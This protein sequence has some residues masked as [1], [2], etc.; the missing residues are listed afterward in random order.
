MLTYLNVELLI[1]TFGSIT[2]PNSSMAL[3]MSRVAI[4]DTM[5]SQ[6]DELTRC[7]PGHILQRKYMQCQITDGQERKKRDVDTPSAKTEYIILRVTESRYIWVH[8]LKEPFR[9]KHVWVWIQLL[10]SKYC[11][12][13][14]T[15]SS[16]VRSRQPA[17]QPIPD[18]SKNLHP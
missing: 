14:E 9:V 11:P 18:V 12:A 13:L 16:S 17:G 1:S 6:M 10:I 8:M 3:E 4:I 15:C 2:L 5:S 7:I